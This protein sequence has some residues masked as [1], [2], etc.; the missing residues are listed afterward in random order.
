MLRKKRER[1]HQYYKDKK[2]S[3]LQ[4]KI[5]E[6]SQWDQS[7]PYDMYKKNQKENAEYFQNLWGDPLEKERQSQLDYHKQINKTGKNHNV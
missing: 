7:L 3:K 1:R 2:Q 6:K 4:E 5:Q